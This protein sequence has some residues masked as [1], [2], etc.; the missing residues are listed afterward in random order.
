MLYICSYGCTDSSKLTI[1][2]AFSEMIR[3]NDSVTRITAIIMIGAFKETTLTKT[4]LDHLEKASGIEKTAVLYSLSIYKNDY[5]DAF[6]ESLPQ[7]EKGIKEL[8]AVESPEGSYFRAP[9]LKIISYLGDIA[10]YNDKALEKLKIIQPYADGWQGDIIMELI[11]A[12]SK[13]RKK[14]I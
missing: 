3:S 8:L 10:V 12:A 11:I 6:I 4:L 1:E 9:Q 7:D 14:N 5:L 13:S 2:K